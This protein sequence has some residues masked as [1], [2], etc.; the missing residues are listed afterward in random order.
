MIKLKQG[1]I[2]TIF[3]VIVAYTPDAKRRLWKQQALLGNARYI[4]ARNKRTTI[5]QPFYRQ[6]ICKY[7]SITVEWVLETVFSVRSVQSS[8]NKEDN[9]GDP[10]SEGWQLIL[11]LQGRMRRDG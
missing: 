7:A 3:V 6:R 11:T 2:Q 4:H 9:S 1:C 8:F 5:M 10:V